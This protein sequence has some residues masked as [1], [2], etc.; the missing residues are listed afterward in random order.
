MK[1]WLVKFCLRCLQIGRILKSI[2]IAASLMTKMHGGRSPACC[3]HRA[4]VWRFP[5]FWPS[6]VLRQQLTRAGGRSASISSEIM[7]SRKL[8]TPIPNEFGRERGSIMIFPLGHHLAWICK[9]TWAVFGI[10]VSVVTEGAGTNCCNMYAT[11]AASKW[12]PECATQDCQSP[13]E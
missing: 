7:H 8:S 12:S 9:I 4:V 1:E 5:A 10:A 2:V 3:L 6:G 11:T 13:F